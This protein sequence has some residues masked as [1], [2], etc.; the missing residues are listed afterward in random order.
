MAGLY[1]SNL[2]QIAIE[3][4]TITSSSAGLTFTGVDLNNIPGG[5][6]VVNVYA[7]TSGTGTSTITLEHSTALSTTGTNQQVA[8][9]RE[10]LRRY[11]RITVTG[12]TLTQTVTFVA[13]GIAANT[14]TA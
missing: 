11:L 1:I 10:L 2:A 8:V 4:K 13:T 7:V 9:N 6:V 5:A 3:T 12:T 14:A